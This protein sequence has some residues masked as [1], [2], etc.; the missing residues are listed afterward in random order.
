MIFFSDFDGT[1]T[2]EGRELTPDFFHILE[3]LKQRKQELVIVSGRSLSWGHFFLT[4]F[5]Q[6]KACIME[7]GGVILYL[8]SRG[9]IAQMPLVSQ[10]EIDHLAHFTTLLKNHFPHVPLSADS[11]GR[12]TDRAIEFHLMD[13]E[14]IKEVIQFMDQHQINYSRSNVHINF[15]AGEISKYLGVK[16]F[17]QH[18]RPKHKETDCWF[19]GDAPNDQSMFEFFHN[20]VGVSNIKHCLGRLSHKPRIILEGE[21]NA[22][23]KGVLN[24]IKSLA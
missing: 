21:E 1:L 5:P 22:G 9:E 2:M 3:L 11:F 20:S 4:H 23:P 17:L 24:F 19:F 16:H 6:L 12:L 15:W 7:G 13:P 8:D 18:F 10:Q 14:W